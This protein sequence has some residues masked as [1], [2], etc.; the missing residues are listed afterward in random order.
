MLSENNIFPED[1][2]NTIVNALDKSVAKLRG[3]SELENFEKFVGFDVIVEPRGNDAQLSLKIFG[4][5]GEG[6]RVT[7]EPEPILITEVDYPDL[8]AETNQRL[9]LVYN[10]PGLQDLI[11]IAIMDIQ[12]E[13]LS[14]EN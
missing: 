3:S 14:A 10:S 11:N 5:D 8:I 12:N 9:D 2:V 7:L 4:E 1:T 13:L 6:R